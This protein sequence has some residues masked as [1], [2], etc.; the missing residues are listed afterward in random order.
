[1]T[2]I[3]EKEGFVGMGLFGSCDSVSDLVKNGFLLS[4]LAGG[5]G[6]IQLH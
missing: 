1:M 2:Q 5:S 3:E 4:F 6:T